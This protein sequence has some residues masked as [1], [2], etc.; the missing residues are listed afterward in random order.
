MHLRTFE[1]TLVSILTPRNLDFQHF[2]F[3]PTPQRLLLKACMQSTPILN[4]VECLKFCLGS[5]LSMYI[6]ILAV[7]PYI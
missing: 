6:I 5:Q 4:N 1:D 3:T 7:H 2:A